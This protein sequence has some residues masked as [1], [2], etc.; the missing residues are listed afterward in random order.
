MTMN[1]RETVLL[2]ALRVIAS[3]PGK[4]ADESRGIAMRAIDAHGAQVASE[5]GPLRGPLLMWRDS[6]PSERYREGWEATFRARDQRKSGC[7]EGS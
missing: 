5:P 4:D 7:G 3:L 6:T 2:E 1:K